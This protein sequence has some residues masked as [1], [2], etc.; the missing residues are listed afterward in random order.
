MNAR[1]HFIEIVKKYK[2][3]KNIM[4]NYREIHEKGPGNTVCVQRE[5]YIVYIVLQTAETTSPEPFSWIPLYDM[6]G[7]AGG[8]GRRIRP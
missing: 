1:M 4:F 6:G 5:R 7:G 8:R 3:L 2:I